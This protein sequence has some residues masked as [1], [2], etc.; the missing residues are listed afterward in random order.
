[1]DKYSTNDLIL[2]VIRGKPF[3]NVPKEFSLPFHH[4]ELLRKS[5]RVHEKRLSNVVTVCF[6]NLQGFCL[7]HQPNS[8]SRY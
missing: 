3:V 5:L 1:M 7:L 8:C 6:I 2:D 4:G